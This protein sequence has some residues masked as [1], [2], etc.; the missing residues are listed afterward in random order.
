MTKPKIDGVG[1]YGALSGKR[2]EDWLFIDKKYNLPQ[3]LYLYWPYY[4][5]NQLKERAMY[6]H[7]HFVTNDR[8]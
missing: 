6:K 8:S 7:S 5:V 1:K 3:L 4:D 2:E